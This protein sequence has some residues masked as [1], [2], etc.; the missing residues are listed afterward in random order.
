MKAHGIQ[1]SIYSPISSTFPDPRFPIT[2]SHNATKVGS[3]PVLAQGVYVSLIGRDRD[4]V[5]EVAKEVE[6]EVGGKIVTEEEVKRRKDDS[7]LQAKI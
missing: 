5:Q 1:V 3:Y 7:K 4:K 6:T 2:T